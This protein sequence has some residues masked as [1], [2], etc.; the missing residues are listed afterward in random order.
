MCCVESPDASIRFFLGKKF[1]CLHF[2]SVCSTQVWSDDHIDNADFANGIDYILVTADQQTSGI[3][4]HNRKWMSETAGNV[5]ASLS[6]ISN[7]TRPY[8]IYS[9]ISALAVCESLA[10]VIPKDNIQ[11]KWPNDVIVRGKKISGSI[12]HAKS[13][14]NRSIC[15]IG[16]GINVNLSSQHLSAIDQPATSIYSETGKHQ[17]VHEILSRYVEAY[18][19]LTSKFYADSTA[20]FQ[21]FYNK[22]AY[23]GEQISVHDDYS[24]AKLSG[25][26]VGVND[27]GFLLLKDETST[28]II[29]SG[30]IIK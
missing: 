7:T 12:V 20:I 16:V 27:D 5:Y 25:A 2:D 1:L 6:F 15:T 8:R 14:A 29:M 21:N 3:G 18:L 4:T 24:N 9:Q 13:I 22:M 11:F 19:V 10:D 17:D 23:I 26:M 28:R 30:T